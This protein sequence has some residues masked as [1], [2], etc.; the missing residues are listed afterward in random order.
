MLGQHVSIEVRKQTL[1]GRAHF[2]VLEA[3]PYC[4]HSKHIKWVHGSIKP[5]VWSPDSSSKLPE[6]FLAEWAGVSSGFQVHPAHSA[7]MDLDKSGNSAETKPAG[8]IES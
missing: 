2:F 1:W 6:S 8:L 5:P 7:K 3:H 4:A